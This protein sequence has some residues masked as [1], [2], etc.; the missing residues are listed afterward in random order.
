MKSRISKF[1]GLLLCLFCI[2]FCTVQAKVPQQEQDFNSVI[3]ELLVNTPDVKVP[4]RFQSVAFKTVVYSETT[5]SPK[6]STAFNGTNALRDMFGIE[7]QNKKFDTTYVY[8]SKDKP[9]ISKTTT[10]WYLMHEYP[11]GRL[12]FRLYYQ[13]NPAANLMEEGDLLFI[14]KTEDS[15]V[16]MIVVSA[17]SLIQDRLI[18]SFN[19]KKPNEEPFSIQPTTAWYQVFFTPGADCE[20]NIISRIN[21]A[22][23]TIDIAVYSITNRNIVDA[24]I[25]AHKRG[26]KVRVITDKEQEKWYTSLVKELVATGVS[27]RT[28]DSENNNKIE[29]NKFAIF[30]GKEIESGSYNWTNSATQCNSENCMF[31]KQTGKDFSERYEYLWKVYELNKM[32]G[33]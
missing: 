7:K 6:G 11:N 2:A 14:G 27:A 9:V 13:K 4:E 1:L 21:N 33:K 12:R 22:K 18:A 25:A 28:N 3:K 19:I 15:K 29:H 23:Y 8:L 16:F 24:V 20:N 32:I 10:T 26:V 17:K 31:F 30:D 5:K